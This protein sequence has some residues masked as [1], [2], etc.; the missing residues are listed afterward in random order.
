LTHFKKK[1]FLLRKDFFLH[2]NTICNAKAE[3]KL[4]CIWYFGL[5]IPL[6]I[7]KYMN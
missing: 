3:K 2:K 5:R 1:K 4:K 7:Q 6:P